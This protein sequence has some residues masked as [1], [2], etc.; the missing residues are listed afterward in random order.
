MANTK[1]KAILGTQPMSSPVG[2][3]VVNV[4]LQAEVLAANTGSGDLVI[5]GKVPEDCVLVDAIYGS[6]DLDSAGSPAT[7]LSF[8]VINADED[9]LATVI[10][11]G[12]NIAQAGGAARLTPTVAALSILSGTSGKQIGFKFTTASA[13]GAAGTVLLSLSYR[14]VHHDS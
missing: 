10:E 7:V 9:D 3:E 2:S 12:I 8:G 5:L 4:L 6:D 1:S 14:S 13:T 11:A